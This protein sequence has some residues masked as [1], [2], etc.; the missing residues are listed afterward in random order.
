MIHTRRFSSEEEKILRQTF[1]TIDADKNGTL[2]LEE[3]RAFMKASDMES[4]F[5]ELVFFLFDTD[6]NGNISF[7]EFIHFIGAIDELDTNPKLFFKR[8][9]DALDA[10]GS[11]SI[12][13]EE[14]VIFSKLC[15]LPMTESD[16]IKA[17][18]QIDQDGNLSIDFEE[19]CAALGL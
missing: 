19:L 13:P 14:V 11:G 5:A 9:F 18:K 17:I 4:A 8:I 7:E 1:N 12:D 15:G 6:K 3:L 2:D 10:D 16:A